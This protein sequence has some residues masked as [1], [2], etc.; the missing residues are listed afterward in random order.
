[1]NS[2]LG[3]ASVCRPVNQSCDCWVWELGVQRMQRSLRVRCCGVDRCCVGHLR[4]RLQRTLGRS[5]G[6]VRLYGRVCLRG[7]PAYWLG[8][9]T[10]IGKRSCLLL[11]NGSLSLAVPATRSDT[12]RLARTSRS[13]I[14]PCSRSGIGNRSWLRGSPGTAPPVTV[15]HAT[16]L[17]ACGRLR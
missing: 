12:N 9:S 16:S 2:R 7:P 17:C 14:C 15:G 10:V 5:E 1:M 11:G 13:T 4:V 8:G 6:H 3:V